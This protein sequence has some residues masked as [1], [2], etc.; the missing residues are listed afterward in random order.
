MARCPKCGSEI[1][2]DENGYICSECGTRLKPK[3]KTPITKEEVLERPKKKPAPKAPE[4]PRTKE[5]RAVSKPEVTSKKRVREQEA[6]EREVK[7]RQRVK[8]KPQKV[9]KNKTCPVCNEVILSERA[10]F[11]EI[12]GAPLKDRVTPLPE[13]KGRLLNKKPVQTRKNV[14]QP[15]DS[16]GLTKMVILIILAVLALG[17]SGFLIFNLIAGDKIK[18]KAEEVPPVENGTE[19][20]ATGADAYSLYDAVFVSGSDVLE[21]IENFKNDDIAISVKND[22]YPKDS[23]SM[24][25]N[26]T[27]GDFWF[28]KSSLTS[29]D[30]FSENDENLLL[31]DARNINNPAF[32][33]PQAEYYGYVNRSGSGEALGISF[34]KIQ[35]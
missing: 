11:C 4:K 5:R 29:A 20:A 30:K 2:K 24:I 6:K 9:K 35:P 8:E 31:N 22:P 14:S 32:I 26:E 7:E 18:S 16:G 21:A 23:I 12:C 28:I 13:K 27:T 15:K 17:I 19:A 3:K 25:G 34:F 33:D 10:N 1:I